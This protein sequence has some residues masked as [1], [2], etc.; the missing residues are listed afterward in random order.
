MKD[1]IGCEL[2]NESDRARF[3]IHFFDNNTERTKEYIAKSAKEAMD[4]VAKITYLIVRTRR[5]RAGS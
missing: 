4:I 5:I 3:V 2:S 1:M